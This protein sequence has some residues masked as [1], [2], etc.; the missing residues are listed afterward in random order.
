MYDSVEGRASGRSGE[1]FPGGVSVLVPVDDSI[2]VRRTVVSFVCELSSVEVAF[3]LSP[4]RGRYSIV[5][6]VIITPDLNF[7]WKVNIDVNMRYSN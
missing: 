1:D 7:L 6:I 5:D 3:D 4:I 2:V